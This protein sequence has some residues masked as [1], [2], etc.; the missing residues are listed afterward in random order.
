[1]PGI[2]QP[3][4]KPIPKP[5]AW[6]EVDIS[7]YRSWVESN[8]AKYVN[9][10]T[11]DCADFALFLLIEFANSNNLRVG[12]KASISWKDPFAD[13]RMKMP[14]LEEAQRRLGAKD[15]YD[16][17]SG[18][19]VEVDFSKLLSGDLLTSKVHVQV[20]LSPNSVVTVKDVVKKTSESNIPVMEIL[21][22]NLG[23]GKAVLV[24]RRAY[25]LRKNANG[26]RNDTY[27]EYNDAAKYYYPA[28]Q[29]VDEKT[30]FKTRRWNFARF[31][32]VP[33][34]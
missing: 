2:L 30:A 15:L 34:E 7:L 22:G 26:S 33:F 4:A 31:N 21:Q 27:Y 20:V 23:S 32:A 8:A 18:N 3:A 14:T 16:T 9:K 12:F 29:K 13:L 17:G 6:T 24:Q 11:V 19:T 5:R 1:V 25:D 10:M 28:D